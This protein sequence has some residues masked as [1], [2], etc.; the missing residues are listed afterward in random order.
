MKDPSVPNA[1]ESLSL[2]M[3]QII[4]GNLQRLNNGLITFFDYI[5]PHTHSTLGLN[6]FVKK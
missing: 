6:K 5:N 2:E 4:L 1:R 3:F